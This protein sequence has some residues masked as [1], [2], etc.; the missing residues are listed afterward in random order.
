MLAATDHDAYVEPFVGMGGVFLRRRTRPSV[1]VINDV[2]GDVVTLFR[3]LQRFPDPHIDAAVTTLE[4][5]RA[6]RPAFRKS[7]RPTERTRLLG[8]L[9]DL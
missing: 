5:R 4:R 9:V 1:E 3:V 2:S 6:S 8:E 7:R